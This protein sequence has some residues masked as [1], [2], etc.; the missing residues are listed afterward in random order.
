MRR[1]QTYTDLMTDLKGKVINYMVDIFSKETL[2]IS[3]Q[4]Q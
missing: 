1:E 2:Q 3:R 4:I